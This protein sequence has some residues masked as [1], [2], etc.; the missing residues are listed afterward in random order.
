MPETKTSKR[1]LLAAERKL[2]AF[3]LRKAGANYN[4]IAAKLGYSQQAAYKSV[5]AHLQDLIAQ[6]NEIA[7][8][9]RRLEIERLD[10]MLLGLWKDASTGNEV[11]VDRVIKIMDQRAKLLGLYAPIKQTIEEKIGEI[12]SL[13][14]EQLEEII[15]NG[16]SKK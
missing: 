9:V 15:L 6:T 3:E 11:K 4:Q 7:D 10:A 5:M 8:D 1:K 2:Q 16:C 12:G 14:N 13:T